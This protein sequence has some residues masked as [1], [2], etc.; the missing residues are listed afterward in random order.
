MADEVT[1]KIAKPIVNPAIATKPDETHPTKEGAKP[2]SPKTEVK[3]ELTSEEIEDL[4]PNENYL[5]SPL[6]YDVANY[7]NLESRD[8]DGAKNNLAEI[9]EWAI[10]SCKSNNPG[11]VLLE[12]KK[13]E[14]RLGAPAWGEKRYKNVYRYVKLV[15]QKDSL[16]KE[17]SAFERGNING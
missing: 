5:T 9:T 11:N 16:N 2:D 14:E 15:F 4:I 6:F 3:T 8:Y 17:I 1:E 12:L 13:V 7:F 10:R